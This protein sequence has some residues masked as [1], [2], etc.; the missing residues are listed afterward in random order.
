MSDKIDMITKTIEAVAEVV[1]SDLEGS[2]LKLMVRDLMRFDEQQ[3][4]KALQ[5]CARE[6]KYKLTLQDIISRID[7]GRPGAEEAWA[8][9]PKNE[10]DSIVWT[11]EM[12]KAFG[13]ASSLL[14][15]G[16]EIAARMAFKETYVKEVALA[17]DEAIRVTWIPSLGHDKSGRNGVVREAVITKKLTVEHGVL[18][19]TELAEDSEVKALAVE[20]KFKLPDYSGTGETEQKKLISD[21]VGPV[22]EKMDAAKKESAKTGIAAAREAIK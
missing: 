20:Q 11:S 2:A 14:D 10:A 19:I 17:R 7:D 5:K 15:S 8:A 22:S 1:G 6:C 12:A 18:L 16:D 3:V 9:I 13:V 4:Y 21:I